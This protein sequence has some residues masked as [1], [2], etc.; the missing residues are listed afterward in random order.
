MQLSSRGEAFIKGFETFARMSY[1]DIHGVWTIAWGHTGF[2]RP[3]VPVGPGQTCTDE[4]AEAWFM[5]DVAWAEAGVM[6]LVDV[7]MTQGQFDALV[8]FTFNEGRTA[9]AHSTL[10][11]DLNNGR[12]QQA[13]Q[14][15]LKW[16]YC[17]HREVVGLE[18][19]RRGEMAEFVGEAV[20]A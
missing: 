9:L 8:S 13:A 3:G 16:D 11:T 15:F 7:V 17:D 10:L 5:A 19:R 12:A 20:A 14:E 2:I 6:K 4:E 1:P 18:R